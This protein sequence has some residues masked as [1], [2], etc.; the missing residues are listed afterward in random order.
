MAESY[1][2]RPIFSL[3]R[4]IFAR[5]YSGFGRLGDLRRGSWNR[6]IIVRQIC[7]IVRFMKMPVSNGIFMVS[8]V[9]TMTGW[10]LA[11]IT[12]SATV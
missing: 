11:M 2:N 1:D 9:S 7:V 6:P 12:T 5:P 3:N 8:I 10:A 4:P